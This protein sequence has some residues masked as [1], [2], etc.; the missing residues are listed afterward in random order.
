MEGIIPSK[1]LS[2]VT[3][4]SAS[5]AV[6]SKTSKETMEEIV[7]LAR[8][9]EDVFGRDFALLSV[10]NH[11]AEK[12]TNKMKIKMKQSRSYLID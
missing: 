5:N 3:T 11:Q 9:V 8:T 1:E 4:R 2:G 7:A 12:E 10:E 6:A